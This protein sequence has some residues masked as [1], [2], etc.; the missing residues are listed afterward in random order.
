M[1][2]ECQCKQDV[3]EKEMVRL[4]Q[5]FT[6]HTEPSA[7]HSQ[8]RTSNRDNVTAR[9][10]VRSPQLTT[11]KTSVRVQKALLRGQSTESYSRNRMSRLSKMLEKKFS[12][13]V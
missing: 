3:K 5:T 9:I 12:H 10:I 8:H 4:V 2:A 6:V 13:N 11:T 1:Q 7:G